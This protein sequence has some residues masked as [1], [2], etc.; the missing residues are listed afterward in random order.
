MF[1]VLCLRLPM[2]LEIAKDHMSVYGLI[3]NLSACD[4]SS[5]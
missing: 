4:M 5:W 1:P 3:D 2:L